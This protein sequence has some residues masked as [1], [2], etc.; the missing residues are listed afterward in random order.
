MDHVNPVLIVIEALATLSENFP[1]P[2]TK[3][4]TKM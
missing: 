2:G 3:G 4:F 1:V